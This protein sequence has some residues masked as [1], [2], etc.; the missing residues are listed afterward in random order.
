MA[1]PD[2]L[3]ALVGEAAWASYT[4][5]P[6]YSPD[7]NS[8]ALA[9]LGDARLVAAG[10]LDTL[11]SRAGQLAKFKLDVLEFDFRDTARAYQE[12]AG[13][14]R[15][16]VTTSSESSSTRGFYGGSLDVG[17]SF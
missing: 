16:E 5:H 1:L 15:A 10:V 13:A 17:S 3:E 14:L 2:T 7:T 9:E 6:D 8:R 4:A 11:A 12:R